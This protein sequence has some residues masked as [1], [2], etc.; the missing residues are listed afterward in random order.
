SVWTDGYDTIRRRFE[1]ALSSD[2]QQVLLC[3]DSPGGEVAG[4]FETVRA[5]RAAAKVS[6]I[7]VI[8]FANEHAY[9]AAYALATVADEIYLPVPGGLGSI[10][11]IATL[12]DVSAALQDAGINVEVITSGD[13]KSDGNPLVPLTDPVRERMQARVDALA[14]QFAELVAEQ[15]GG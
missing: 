10:G 13:E 5:M 14:A 1:T 11:V 7:R 9:S 6:G 12:E 4:C 8:A 15:R 3:I 2:A